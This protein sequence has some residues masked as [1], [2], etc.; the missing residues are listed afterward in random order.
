ML[1]L[2]YTYNPS[3]TENKK[4]PLEYKPNDEFNRISG[5]LNAQSEDL[6]RNWTE[7]AGD[8]TYPNGYFKVYPTPLS[9]DKEF[10]LDHYIKEPLFDTFGDLVICPLPQAYEFYAVSMLH[11]DPKRR[12]EFNDKYTRVL[13]SLK[14]MQRRNMGPRELRRVGIPGSKKHFYG[15]GSIRRSQ[16]DKENYW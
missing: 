1:F 12:E 7:I 11:K 8:S 16:S 2:Y 14:R 4:Y 13:N 5:D 9:E 15:F 6:L 10:D 3:S